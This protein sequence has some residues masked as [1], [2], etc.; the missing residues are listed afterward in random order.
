MAVQL[1][2]GRTATRDTPRGR[3]TKLR[4]E[5]IPRSS[6]HLPARAL[7]HDR[8]LAPQISKRTRH[9]PTMRALHARAL[10]LR[11][12]R[13]HHRHRLRRAERQVDPAR[14]ATI[15]ARL[16]DELPAHGMPPLHQCHQL[17][18]ADRLTRRKTKPLPGPI[19][20]M[21]HPLGLRR[22]PRRREVVVPPRRRDRP[23]LQI[24]AI[25][26]R[27]PRTYARSRHH[28]PKSYHPKLSRSGTVHLVYLAF[29]ASAGGLRRRQ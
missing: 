19:K 18:R 1:R 24:R 11:A 10:L 6:E 22:L 5:D 3:V 15:R 28:H 2:V 21:P 13:P 7:P 25:A 12:Q 20:D 9:R 29:C 27:L 14:A 16:T 23:R 8:N 26:R 4:R 17:P